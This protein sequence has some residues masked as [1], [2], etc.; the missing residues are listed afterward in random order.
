LPLIVAISWIL[1]ATVLLRPEK[2][3]LK[4]AA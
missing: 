3:F 4:D 2:F 1:V